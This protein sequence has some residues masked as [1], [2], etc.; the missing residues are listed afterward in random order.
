MEALRRSG[1]S[2]ALAQDHSQRARFRCRDA[3]QGYGQS[4]RRGKSRRSVLDQ[5]R[6]HDLD[7]VFGEADNPV[8]FVRETPAIGRTQSR[9]IRSARRFPLRCYRIPA[10]GAPQAVAAGGP[11]GRR[12]ALWRRPILRLSTIVAS[13]AGRGRAGQGSSTAPSSTGTD[14]SVATWRSRRHGSCRRRWCRSRPWIN[15]AVL[16]YQGNPTAGS[17]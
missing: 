6:R 14:F 15:P 5:G 8:R 3:G 7:I 17:W 11:R 4:P 16:S 9:E 12:H 13:S 1:L 2:G 10:P